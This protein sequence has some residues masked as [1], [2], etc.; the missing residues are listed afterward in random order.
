LDQQD[1]KT[2]NH[3]ASF[4]C[5]AALLSALSP[6][7]SPL[8]TRRGTVLCAAACVIACRVPW[9]CSSGLA[10]LKRTDYRVRHQSCI[11]ATCREHCFGQSY[12]LLPLQYDCISWPAIR[13]VLC[14]T[15]V[16]LKYA[17]FICARNL[18]PGLAL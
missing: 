14:G 10:P 6:S 13:V 4:P 15:L 3:R 7:T 16:G 1:T 8:V 11:V 12:R 2:A 17:F 18:F 9:T 5:A